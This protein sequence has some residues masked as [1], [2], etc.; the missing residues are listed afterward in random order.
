MPEDKWAPVKGYED[1]YEISTNKEIRNKERD[2][3]DP[4]G[5]ILYHVK[6]SCVPT[7]TSYGSKP[8]VILS[9]GVS[10]IREDLEKLYKK[11]FK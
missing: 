8:Y 11:S 2:I 7:Y 5:N 3:K 6:P 4:K 10:S 9:T 1:R